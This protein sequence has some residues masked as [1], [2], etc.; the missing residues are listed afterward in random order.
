[1][2]KLKEQAKRRM[3]E[4]IARRDQ[5]LAFVVTTQQMMTIPLDA[6][7]ATIESAPDAAMSFLDDAKKSSSDLTNALFDLVAEVRLVGVYAAQLKMWGE[8]EG[9]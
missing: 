1:M 6:A 2:N 8:G 3:E 9:A 5:L 4:A 7:G